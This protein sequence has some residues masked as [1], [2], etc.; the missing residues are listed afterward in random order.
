MSPAARPL[1]ARQS[2]MWLDDRLFDDARYHN[3]V[4]RIDLDGPLDRERL[5]GAWTRTIADVDALR[6]QLLPG[7]P[8]QREVAPAGE[9]RIVSVD[10]RSARSWMAERCVRRLGAEGPS[11]DAALL[12]LGPDRHVFHLCLHHALTDFTSMGLIASHL[13]ARYSGAPTIAAPAFLD[14]VRREAEYRESEQAARDREYWNRKLAPAAPPLRPYGVVRTDRSVAVERV[15]CD[16]GTAE[17]S[18]RFAARAQDDAFATASPAVSRL[19]VL[20]TAWA[21]LLHRVTGDRD[22]LLGVPVAN[23]SAEFRNTCGLFM[24][25]AFLRVTVDPGDTFAALGAKVLD[26]LWET[27]RHG[28]HCVSDGALQ[29]AT[30]NLTPPPARP[31]FAGLR[32]TVEVLPAAAVGYRDRPGQGDLRN[33]LG[34][35][36]YHAEDVPL[37]LE[38]DLHRATWTPVQRERIGRHFLAVL[39]ALLDDPSATL[40]EVELL[41]AEERRAVLRHARGPEPAGPPPDLLAILA[42]RTASSPDRPAVVGPDASLTYRQLD[43]RCQRLASRLRALGVGP[44]SRVAVALPRGAGEV[45]ALLATLRAG[46]GYVPVD[47]SHPVERVRI[48]LED[49]APQVLIAPADSPLREAV[50]AGTRLL[51]PAAPGESGG[52]AVAAALPAQA[53]APSGQLAYVLFTS[54]ST[55]RPK[56]V[57]V[58]R[59]ALANFLRSMAT[60]PGLS[61]GECLLAVTTTTF[62]IAALELFLPLHVGATVLVVDRETALDPQRLRGVLETEPVTTMQATPATWRLLVEAGWR[63]RAGLRI[64]CGGEPLTRELADQLLAR[65][66]ELWNLYG[67][68]ETTVWSSLERVLP[69]AERITIGRPIDRTR[70][71]VLDAARRL[72]PA[73]VVGELHIGGDGVARGYCGRPDLTAERFVADPFSP[74][75]RL[76]RTGDLGRVLEDGRLECLGRVDHQVKIHGFRIELGEIESALRGVEGVS[77]AVVLAD[78]QGGPD[79]RL[80]AYWVGAAERRALYDGARTKLPSYMVPSAFVH[81]ASFPLTTSGKIDRKALPPPDGVAHPPREG[82]RPRHD[83]ETRVCLLWSELLGLPD[84]GIDDDFFALGG[85]SVTVIQARARMERELGLELPLRAIFERP[86]VADLLGRLDREPRRAAEPVV[87]RL[88]GG[89]PGRPPL[90]FLLGVQLYQDVARRLAGE[91][92]VVAMHVPFP[93][94]PGRDPFPTVETVATRYVG[95]I[96]RIQPHGPYR[97]AGLCFGGVVAFEAGRQLEAAGEPVSMVAVFD[98]RLPRRLDPAR[99]LWNRVRSG[100]RHPGRLLGALTGSG[101]RDPGVADVGRLAPAVVATATTDLPVAGPQ[102]RRE[103]AR[104]RRRVTPIRGELVVLRAL[105]PGGVV[106]LADPELGW[107][108]LARTITAHPVEA[109]HLEMVRDPHAGRLGLLLG[110]ALARAD[111]AAP[112]EAPPALSIAIP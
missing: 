16:P 48:I 46:G 36:A 107:T 25:Q 106:A 86:T 27:L 79:A 103:L 68:T 33:T 22:V 62:D 38:L 93:H 89:R 8:A 14:H 19:A 81:L 92:P 51:D 3:S 61:P 12:V 65:G 75:A 105:P 109:G 39:D 49:A 94:V 78:A 37:R 31:S 104:Y 64:L 45:V 72:V 42:E 34:L 85:T 29:F 40:E 35:R 54:G 1:T 55:G 88:R 83:L 87:V 6:L 47:P 23:R 53:A 84:V 4:L 96:R 17:R 30:L 102:V 24:Q 76:Y 90:I 101:G 11:W 111:R 95:E 73:G 52:E 70:I 110:D 2:L 10:E 100:A 18:R 43:D 15:A 67:P 28:A 44:E 5:A 50:P 9:L 32:A 82:R 66:A 58:T 21:A 60:A 74:G 80:I 98:G 77:E 20:A 41:D 26:D 69:G 13:A 97:L 56:G 57:E 59:G 112:A 7:E 108:G 99:R 63:G 91:D 71:H